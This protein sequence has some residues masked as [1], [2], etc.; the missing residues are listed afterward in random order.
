[1]HPVVAESP[2]YGLHERVAKRQLPEKQVS[3]RAPSDLAG[4]A[5]GDLLEQ[6]DRGQKVPVSA[7]EVAEDFRGQ[8]LGGQPVELSVISTGLQS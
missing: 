7:G 6:A 1:V 3:I 2:S 4:Q 5:G 8:V